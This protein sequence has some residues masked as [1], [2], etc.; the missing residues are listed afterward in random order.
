MR[1]GNVLEL[2]VRSIPRPQRRE[3]IM[4]T[5]DALQIGGEL[6]I[7]SDHEPRFLRGEFERARPG[8][9]VWTQRMH[10]ADHWEVTLRRVAPPRT[11]RI[12]EFLKRCA[13]FDD[14]SA[15]TLTALED[16]AVDQRLDHN[17][18][19]SE[20]G[21]EWDGFGLVEHGTLAAIITSPLGREHALYDILT[22]EPFGEISTID[23]GVTV[24]RFVVTSR[25]ARVV[26]FPKHVVRSALENDPALARGM[27]EVCAQRMRALVDRFAAQ[28][29][30]PTVARVA[31]ALLPHA[32]PQ[33]G[34]HPV[35][36][37]FHN[38]TQ[39]ELATAA[40]TV[41]EV[42]SRALAELEDAGAIERSGGHIVRVD[43]EKL[44]RYAGCL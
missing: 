38:L 40:G 20:Q 30:L 15:Q 29:S 1:E 9:Y 18:T 37:S 43:R 22:A 31:A 13:L 5:F 17:E 25:S 2:D 24:A 7:V 21:A 11:P 42:V 35:L 12:R 36:P 33:S 14:A 4:E 39:V 34:L 32:G 41:K 27:N 16:A 3:R 10:S 23:G 28:T 6:R 8:T 26:L 19:V 44:T